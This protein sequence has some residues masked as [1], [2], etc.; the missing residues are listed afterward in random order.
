M[1][2]TRVQAYLTSSCTSEAVMCK[3][4]CAMW[5]GAIQG[6]AARYGGPKRL[7]AESWIKLMGPAPSAPP[8]K[9]YSTV[10]LP[11]VSILNTSCAPRNPVLPMPASRHKTSG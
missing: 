7:P 8:A 3:G 2:G 1:I 5:N 4:V 11:E 9:L 6:V 10:S